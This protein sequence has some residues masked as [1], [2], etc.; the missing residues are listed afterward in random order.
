MTLSSELGI[1]HFPRPRIVIADREGSEKPVSCYHV[2]RREMSRGTSTGISIKSVSKHLV[3]EP[4]LCL[5]VDKRDNRGDDRPARERG[6]SA[7]GFFL[8]LSLDVLPW[9]ILVRVLQMMVPQIG[10]LLRSLHPLRFPPARAGARQFDAPAILSLVRRR[11]QVLDG[12]QLSVGAKRIDLSYALT[13]VREDTKVQG[14]VL[15]C[16]ICTSRDLK[17][18]YRTSS[19]ECLPFK[20]VT[21]RDRNTN[22]LLVKI[23]KNWHESLVT[24]QVISKRLKAMGMIQKQGNWAETTNVNGECR[25]VTYTDSYGTTS[26]CSLSKALKCIADNQITQFIECHDIRDPVTVNVHLH[27]LPKN[28]LYAIHRLNGDIK[29][30]LEAGMT[31]R[32]NLSF[33]QLKIYKHLIPRSLR[34]KLGTIF[35]FL[36]FDYCCTVMIDVTG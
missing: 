18:D 23:K 25:G 14:Q 36:I 32:I 4:C 27:T 34:F 20:E 30:I 22:T 8:M 5:S 6:R 2:G 29:S 31:S 12:W 3:N 7:G 13:V 33:Y 11:F 21:L 9:R 19:V 17:A 16:P 24:Q 26:S 10:K 28:V 15:H 35:I 1:S